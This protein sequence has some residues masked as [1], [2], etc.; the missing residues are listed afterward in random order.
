MLT[1]MNDSDLTPQIVLLDQY[2]P[3]HD[4][5]V[6]QLLGEDMSA[7]R[8]RARQNTFKGLPLPVVAYLSLQMLKC[9]EAL[10]LKGFVH[11]YD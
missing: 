8:R 9:I 6:M 5:I 2:A 4:F 1:A 3:E 10:H 11:R 7:L